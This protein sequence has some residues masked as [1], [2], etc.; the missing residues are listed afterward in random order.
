MIFLENSAVLGRYV[1]TQLTYMP[2]YTIAAR[3]SPPHPNI[4]S[5]KQAAVCPFL[6]SH[7]C[8]VLKYRVVWWVRSSFLRNAASLSLGSKCLGDWGRIS[9]DLSVLRSSHHSKIFELFMN[10]LARA[11]NWF[12]SWVT[13]IRSVTTVLILHPRPHLTN[14]SHPLGHFWLSLSF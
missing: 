3:G 14:L 11:D 7:Y 1:Y 10:V 8:L 6:N 9:S 2:M 4:H 13:C 12:P 5:A